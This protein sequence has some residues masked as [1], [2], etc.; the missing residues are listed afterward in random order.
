MKISIAQRV[1]ASYRKRFGKPKSRVRKY[2]DRTL[3]VLVGIWVVLLIFPQPLFAY[4]VKVGRFS[5]YSDRPI[6]T[7]IEGVIA[8]A[9]SRLSASPYNSSEDTFSLIIASS[10]WRRMLMNPIGAKAFGTSNTL[11]GHT[12][13]N[14]SDVSADL[15]FNSMPNNN[16]RS[17]HSVI[18]HEC[19]HQLLRRRLGIVQALT[20][21]TWKNEGYC[22]YVAGE[23]SFDVS[24]GIKLLA[25]GQSHPSP[26]FQYLK[27]YLAVRQALD[28]NGLSIDELVSTNVAAEPLVKQAAEMLGSPE[29]GDTVQP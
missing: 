10:T 22:E 19:T 9:D 24:N 3:S 14:R 27:Y 12:V 8:L 20:L 29:G 4:S 21:P 1:I 25:N 16:Q 15:C 26:S 2:V 7:N 6:P 28:V 17:L 13:L 23:P 5:V 18:A 11:T